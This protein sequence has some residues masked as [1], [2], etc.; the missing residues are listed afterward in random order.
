MNATPSARRSRPLWL[1]VLLS[2]LL[3][4][5]AACSDSP[6]PAPI[7]SVLPNDTSATVG[8]A[9]TLSAD[10]GSTWTHIAGATQ[11]SHITSAGNVRCAGNNSAGQ[12]GDGTATSNPAPVLVIAAANGANIGN[13][14]ALAA[15][16]RALAAGFQHTCALRDDRSMLCWGSNNEGQL[17][18]GDTA[19]RTTPTAVLGGARFAG[20]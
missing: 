7:I 10:A 2:A 19:P 9:A 17:G 11:A 15:G 14:V 4:A 18:T 8:S 5:L 12:L 16:V 3:G 6:P 1:W 20:P 13:V